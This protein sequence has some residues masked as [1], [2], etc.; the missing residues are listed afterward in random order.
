MKHAS[1]AIDADG[2]AG[3]LTLAISASMRVL[4]ERHPSVAAFAAALAAR[5][6]R[7]RLSR[8]AVYDWEGGRSQVTAAVW[9]TAARL[10]GMTL[11]EALAAG[12]RRARPASRTTFS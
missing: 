4:R 1:G 6:G 5:T 7:S 3:E 12:R 8:Q 2:S 11:E 10:A 9:I